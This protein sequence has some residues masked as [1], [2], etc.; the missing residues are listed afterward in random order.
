M[1]KIPHKRDHLVFAAVHQSESAYKKAVIIENLFSIIR[2]V[3]YGVII[4]SAKSDVLPVVS[5]LIKAGN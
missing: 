3:I 1:S 4:L 5:E 2:H